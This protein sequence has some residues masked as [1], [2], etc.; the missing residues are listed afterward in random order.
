MLPSV[1][2][3]R[4][5]PFG[6]IRSGRGTSV[7]PAPGRVGSQGKH[8]GSMCVSR[9]ILR[10]RTAPWISQRTQG[11][12]TRPM[13]GSREGRP[14][15]VTPSGL[16]KLPLR[17]RPPPLQRPTGLAL[18]LRGARWPPRLRVC[19][20]IRLLSWSHGAVQKTLHGSSPRKDK[21]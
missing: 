18:R 9:G 21:G 16:L 15:T 8:P 13:A 6:R 7:S 5:L 17:A 12:I 14:T 19:L 20:L 2:I 4:V 1:K 10:S 3:H 11:L